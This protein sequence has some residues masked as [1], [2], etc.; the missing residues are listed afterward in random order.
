MVCT[1]NRENS[2]IISYDRGCRGDF[3][4]PT[5]QSISVSAC[6]ALASVTSLLPQETSLDPSLSAT[7]FSVATTTSVSKKSVKPT[8]ISIPN[9]PAASTPASDASFI[10]YGSLSLMLIGFLIM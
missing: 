2:C 9:I 1:Q 7:T 6:G 4:V 10:G 5:Q 3:N 8:P